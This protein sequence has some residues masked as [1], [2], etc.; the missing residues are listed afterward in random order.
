[1]PTVLSLYRACDPDVMFFIAGDRKTDDLAVTNFLIDIPNHAYYG[2]DT[3]HKLGYKCSRLLGENTI[4]RRNIMLLEALKWGADVIVTVD[5]D[6]IPLDKTYFSNF[7]T[8]SWASQAIKKINITQEV[9]S[10][11][12]N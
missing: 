12:R 6:N 1:M 11:R 8:V 9:P 2:I 4:T 7:E 5:D 10:P 3:Q